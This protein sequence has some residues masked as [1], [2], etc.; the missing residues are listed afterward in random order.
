MMPAAVLS[1]LVQTQGATV[2]TAQ[3]GALDAA[4][5]KAGSGVEKSGGKIAGALGVVAKGAGLG[6]I[7][8]GGLAVAAISAAA[9]YEQSMNKLQ[10]VSG[11]TGD[12]MK[13]LSKL[14]MK[15][16]ADAKL[17]GTSAKD[18]AQAMTE[19]TKAGLSLTDTMAGARSVLV[20]SAAAEIDNAKAAEIASNA[21]NTFGLEG[22]DVTL[23]ADQLANVANAS[24]VE[25]TD[26]ADATK[27]AG[28]VFASFQGPVRGAKGAMTDL[29]VAI[30]ILGNAGIK[31]SDA[32]TSLKQ[33][34][35]Q[36]A[37]PAEKTKNLMRD[38]YL[39]TDGSAQA[40]RLFT[41]SIEGA[42]KTIREKASA[43]LEKLQGSTKGMGDIAYDAAGQMRSLP[44]IID[45]VTRA[46]KGMTQ[47]QRNQAITQIFGADAS[48]AV[49]VL[50][51]QGP[52]AWDKMT[53]AVTKQGAA[54]DLAAAKMKGFK[55]AM[56]AFKST[57]E[58]LA[59]TVGTMLLPAATKMMQWINTG[60]GAIA[61]FTAKLSDG[62]GETSKLGETVKTV[63]EAIKTGVAASVEF[64]QGLLVEHKDDI[65]NVEEAARNVWVGMQFAWEQSILPMIKR[66]L[67]AIQQLVKGAFDVI[68]GIIKT[69]SSLLTGDFGAAWDGVKQ[70]FKGA[71][72]IILG[73]FRGFTAP[74]REVASKV[75]EAIKLALDGAWESVKSAV[76]AVGTWFDERWV[77]IKTAASTAWEKVKTAIV[78]PISE[79][80]DAVKGALGKGKEGMVTW[81]GDRVSDVKDVMDRLAD[82]FIKAFDRMTSSV[83]GLLD[84]AGKV[85]DAIK[86]VVDWVEKIKIPKIDIPLIGGG[87]K[88]GSAGGG[89]GGGGLQLPASFSA[90]HQTGGLPG[91]P[92]TD[93]FGPPGQAVLAPAAGV[94]SKLSGSAGG[95]GGGGAFGYSMYLRSANGEYFLTHFGSRAVS[96]GQQVSRGQLLGT[97][98]DYPD[99]ADHIHMGLRAFAKGGIVRPGGWALVGER[100]PELAHL[101]SG[102]NVYSNRDSRGMLS[103]GS[104]IVLDA[105]IDLGRG[106]TQRIKLEFDEQGRQLKGAYMAGLT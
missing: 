67:P 25:I 22:K 89:G 56:E 82:P 9:D 64:L 55:G 68:G 66:V 43:A 65:E 35:L 32:G 5:A 71:L 23:V 58:T 61:E 14:A 51:Q 6:A 78:T 102:T 77:D 17:P 50:M 52:D 81:L 59:I 88:P 92:A 90:T 47:E 3:L 97:I 104:P 45:Q 30:G 93:I 15:L 103:G 19:M 38:L 98:A 4:G 62:S 75:G 29:N 24:S 83:K 40:Q 1:I 21:L 76:R 72:E 106:I 46:T 60:A 7:A 73:N 31:G 41:M 96:L 42:T 39:Q 48:R 13:D 105:V 100:G 101:P 63:W 95:P 57:L 94:I 99:R 12:Q 79:A 8:V 26:V 84:F 74:L 37:A 27:M 91:Y 2:A 16:G 54:Q 33:A 87:Y 36:L 80:I 34:L 49:L 28:A 44:D 10:S 20:L 11:A 85:V 53:A 86:E 69:I 18:A 70:I